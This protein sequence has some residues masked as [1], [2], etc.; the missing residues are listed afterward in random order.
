MGR[1]IAR[2]CRKDDL[3]RELDRPGFWFQLDHL[4]QVSFTSE[5]AVTIALT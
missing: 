3:A 4:E 2:A 5:D 1:T